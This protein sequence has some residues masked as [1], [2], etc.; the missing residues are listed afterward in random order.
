MTATAILFNY[1]VEQELNLDFIFGSLGDPT[2]RDIL[3]RISDHSMSI[4]A[5]A[6]HYNFSFAG[7]AK[8]LDVL[9][10]AG[11]VHKTKRGKEQIV[12][13]DPVA[14][15]RAAKYLEGYRQLWEKRL[16][17]LDTYLNA[18]TKEG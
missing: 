12:S 2:R 14:L 11:L 15:E 9:E 13:I 16:D 10:R 4:S 17:T 5:I 3:S 1:M 8:H 6:R 18:I 7:V